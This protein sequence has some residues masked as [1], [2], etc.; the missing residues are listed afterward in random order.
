MTSKREDRAAR[1]EQM[2]KD[3]ERS[4]KR[5]RSVIS[6]A[7][8]VVVA[9]LIALAAWAIETSRPHYEGDVIRPHGATK[10][11]GIVYD[12]VAAGATAP[13]TKP[14]TVEFYEDFQCPA[15]LQFEQTSAPT[16]IGL[17]KTG[18]ITVVFK[19]WSFLDGMG[20]SLNEYSH[21]STNVALLVLEKGGAAKYFAFHN[22]LYAHQPDEN[23]AGPSDNELI[24]AAKTLGVTVDARA[25]KD[26]KFFP[27]IDAARKAGTK[28]GV[29][30]TPSLFVDG[31]QV[32][33]PKDQN[34]NPTAPSLALILQ[35]IDQATKK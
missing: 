12:A 7:V 34:G 13:K 4:A 22:Y 20:R 10:D 25:V 24:A 3:R 27:W 15:C 5:Q 18:K 23:T 21:R 6:I 35:A 28:R 16:L 26:R 31:K 32:L 14:V 1:A 17:V 29:T 9:A 11:Y 30:S 8:L 2:R 33:G 19:P